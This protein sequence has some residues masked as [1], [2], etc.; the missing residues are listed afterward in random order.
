LGDDKLNELVSVVITTYNRKQLFLE[1][2][3]SVKSQSWKALDIVV[4]DDGSDMLTLT[5]DE[6][7]TLG[8]RYFYIK[9]SGQSAARNFGIAQ[10]R[11]EY[12]AFID[13]DD[14]WMPERIARQMEV[15]SKGFDWVY[16]DTGIFLNQKTNILN[17][18]SQLHKPLQGM[19]FK[20]LLNGCFISS[21]SVLIKKRIL[22]SGSRFFE[23]REARYG[24]DWFMWLR[25]AA[26]NRL[27]YLPEVLCLYRLHS[28]SM[29]ERGD[30]H[31][32]QN[33]HRLGLEWVFSNVPDTY[34]KLRAYA[35][36]SA[37]A[38]LAKIAYGRRDRINSIVF[39][40]ESIRIKPSLKNIIIYILAHSP[41]W[42]HSSWKWIRK[43]RNLITD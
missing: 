12:V 32:V 21:P 15:M 36:A 29:L 10:A 31:L 14:L 24:E 11:G 19:I 7:K 26:H 35:L 13:D 25:L 37:N 33:S 38:N 2:L 8:I 4:V 28:E 43:R 18:Y 23:D 22:D 16:C 9:N 5:D 6:A 17:L 42:I 34:K 20:E 39:S 1:T 3:D 27:G 30:L 41:F 40:R